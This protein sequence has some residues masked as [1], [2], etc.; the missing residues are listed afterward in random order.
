MSYTPS[1]IYLMYYLD[2]NGKKIY[3][4]V[5][6]DKDKAL[7]EVHIRGNY[8]LEEMDVAYTPKKNISGSTVR[9]VFTFIRESSSA[10][11]H[12][13]QNHNGTNHYFFLGKTI[14]DFIRNKDSLNFNYIMPISLKKDAEGVSSGTVTSKLIEYGKQTQVSVTKSSKDLSKDIFVYYDTT[15]KRTFNR[16]FV[17]RFGIMAAKDRDSLFNIRLAMQNFNVGPAIEITNDIKEKM[18]EIQDY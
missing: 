13:G 3:S 1:T 15:Q 5:F 7:M 12:D 11:I 17:A 8:F 16:A 9:S 2:E 10:V 18:K 4:E 14:Y 6:Q